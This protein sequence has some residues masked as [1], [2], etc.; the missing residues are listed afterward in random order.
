MSPQTETLQ[1]HMKPETRTKTGLLSDRHKPTLELM[2]SQ[3]RKSI[4]FKKIKP[5]IY[6]QIPR[7]SMKSL[8]IIQS[9]AH[10]IK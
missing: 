8:I 9:Q 7:I 2:H 6:N 5:F 1:A 10:I 3:T 4:L